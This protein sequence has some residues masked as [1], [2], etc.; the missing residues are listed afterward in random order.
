MINMIEAKA[1]STDKGRIKDR[2]MDNNNLIKGSKAVNS[3]DNFNSR[4]RVK[5]KVA[6]CVHLPVLQIAVRALKPLV[7]VSL[8]KPNLRPSRLRI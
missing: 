3:K 2:G 1:T 5:V 7:T 4:V 8:A 6:V